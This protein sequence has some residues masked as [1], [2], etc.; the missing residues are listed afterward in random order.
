MAVSVKLSLKNAIE[1][2]PQPINRL[3]HKYY[4]ELPST[5]TK[6]QAA[7]KEIEGYF[8]TFMSDAAPAIE[9]RTELLCAM[10]LASTNVSE[11]L[12]IVDALHKSAAAEG[13]V[14]E[15]GVARGATSALIANEIRNTN[16]H[17][18]LYDSFQGLPAPSEDDLLVDDVAARG[19]MAR[20]KGM[21]AHPEAAVRNR[22]AHIG[23][24]AERTHIVRGW[25]EDLVRS[26]ELPS[27]VSFAYVD[28]D[29][30]LPI[31]TAL[32]LVDERLEIGGHVIIDDYGYF[33]G[34]A[35]KAADEFLAARKESY[36]IQHPPEFCGHFL[37]LNRAE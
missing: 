32:E 13:D 36:T 26:G 23:F 17:L 10:V 24:P 19:S 7:V 4:H 25:V 35:K 37:I 5:R 33:S 22:L 34:G 6:Y 20:Y 14:C 16:K 28:L 27:K 8:R 12:F 18:W 30:Y 2:L 1:H 9:N 15:F 21:M 29:F 3:Y 31:R 11:A